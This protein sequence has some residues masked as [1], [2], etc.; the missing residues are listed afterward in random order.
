[1]PENIEL[2]TVNFTTVVQVT[3]DQSYKEQEKETAFKKAIR[4]LQKEV[5]R[6]QNLAF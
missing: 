3:L 4:D 2:V 1:M 5:I 6:L